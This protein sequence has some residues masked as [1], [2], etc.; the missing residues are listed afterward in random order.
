MTASRHEQINFI[1]EQALDRADANERKEF[2]REA[3][4]GDA[5]LLEAVERLLRRDAQSDSLLDK[6]VRL[7]REG[8]M[9]ED[10]GIADRPHHPGTTVVQE[11]T[12]PKQLGK[13]VIRRELGRGGMG[14]V[15]EA[16]AP[17][18]ARAVAIKLPLVPP[19]PEFRVQMLNEARAAA[20]VRHPG[21]VLIHDVVEGH[22][23]PFLVF[24]YVEGTTLALRLKELGH[25]SLQQ[26]VRY[27]AEAADA[28]AAAHAEGVIHRDV[29]PQNIMLTREDRVK[30]LD[31]GIARCRGDA[32]APELAREGDLLGSID[33]MSPEQARDPAKVDHR[34]D[35]YSLGCTLFHLIEGTPPFTG[36]LSQRLQ[37]H[38]D[39]PP[40]GL[41]RR[42]ETDETVRCQVEPIV[43]EMMAKDPADR[44]QSMSEVATALRAAIRTPTRNPGFRLD[45]RLMV[46]ALASA[47]IA[48][49][50]AVWWW[51]RPTSFHFSFKGAVDPVEIDHL[52]KVRDRLRASTEWVAE[53][54]A[55]DAVVDV[56]AKLIAREPAVRSFKEL[57]KAGQYRELGRVN[58]ITAELAAQH[59]IQ[60]NNAIAKLVRDDS[61]TNL[62]RRWDAPAFPPPARPT[63]EERWIDAFCKAVDR[64]VGKLA[65]YYEQIRQARETTLGGS[66]RGGKFI[67]R[68]TAGETEFQGEH[69]VARYSVWFRQPTDAERLLSGSARTDKPTIMNAAQAPS[70]RPVAEFDTGVRLTGVRFVPLSDGS[71]VELDWSSGRPQID[72][73]A[74]RGFLRDVGVPAA[75]DVADERLEFCSL[76]PRPEIQAAFRLV[77]HDLSECLA[78]NSVTLDFLGATPLRFAHSDLS[79]L[80]NPLRRLLAQANQYRG[81]PIVVGKKPTEGNECRCA[82]RVQ[83][84]PDLDFSVGFDNEWNIRFTGAPSVAARDELARKL[85]RESSQL[86]PLGPLAT[87]TNLQIAEVPA[88]V[89]GKLILTPE[90]AYGP[91]P[92]PESGAEFTLTANGQFHVTLPP[93]WRSWLDGVTKKISPKPS[94]ISRSDLERCVRA[95][96]ARRPELEG[97]VEIGGVEVGDL[98]AL[99]TLSVSVGDWPQLRLGPLAVNSLEKTGADIDAALSEESLVRASQKQ[100]TRT[101]RHPRFGESQT[102]LVSWRPREGVAEVATQMYFGAIDAHLDVNERVRFGPKRSSV[103]ETRDPLDGSWLASNAE[104]L[105]ASASPHINEFCGGASKA[106]KLATGI[107]A[108]L[109]V[110]DDGGQRNDW[111]QLSPPSLRLKGQVFIPLL[112]ARVEVKGVSINERGI[113]VSRVPI[114]LERTFYTTHFAVSDPKIVIDFEN[115][116]LG[117]GVSITPPMPPI[118]DI[119]QTGSLGA[120]TQIHDLLPPDHATRLAG[121]FPI[122][123]SRRI[124]W[125]NP[126]LHFFRADFQVSGN[127]AERV[128]GAAVAH[129]SGRTS[130]TRRAQTLGVD[131]HLVVLDSHSLVD[132]QG[133][134]SLEGGRFRSLRASAAG[135][136]AAYSSS[137]SRVEGDFAIVAGEGTSLAG[138]FSLADIRIDGRVTFE[139]SQSPMRFGIDGNARLPLIGVVKLH[140]SSDLQFNDYQLRAEGFMDLPGWNGTRR[141]HCRYYQTPNNS[142]TEW[143]WTT[144][145]GREV[146]FATD[147][148]SGMPLDEVAMLDELQN[149]V[150]ISDSANVRELRAEHARELL[151]NLPGQP[152][153]H[154]QPIASSASLASAGYLLVAE[155]VTASEYGTGDTD[156]TTNPNEDPVLE[157]GRARGFPPSSLGV[158]LD[159]RIVDDVLMVVA[160]GTNSVLASV[161]AA[162]AGVK[163]WTHCR[164]YLG[165]TS[166]GTI[167]LIL[168]ENFDGRAEGQF[169]SIVF[170]SPTA[171]RCPAVPAREEH[172]VFARRAGAFDATSVRGAAASW[173]VAEAVELAING[174]DVEAIQETN[175]VFIALANPP[176]SPQRKVAVFGWVDTI[177]PRRAIARSDEIDLHTPIE[178]AE[179]LTSALQRHLSSAR[180]YADVVVGFQPAESQDGS[181]SRLAVLRQIGRHDY[182]LEVS[183]AEGSRSVDV[184]VGDGVDFSRVATIAKCCAE[185]IWHGSLPVCESLH[186]GAAGTCGIHPLGWILVSSKDQERTGW[187]DA[188]RLSRR[189]FEQ[190]Q[191]PSAEL[192]PAVWRS[193]ES[194][195][196]LSAEQLDTLTRQIVSS[197]SL[198]RNAQEKDRWKAHPMGLLIERARQAISDDER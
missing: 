20:R 197:W 178:L 127:L 48:L 104:S 183:S 34:T 112:E 135:E 190:W 42:P 171:C 55:G 176:Q 157:E 187:Q 37:A 33:Y 151:Q 22:D 154:D 93:A 193:P 9:A 2:V 173:M 56:V 32:Q 107:D 13:F 156:D 6:S 94:S 54:T 194:R 12:L 184:K 81:L 160:Q 102:R 121:A 114:V 162:Q 1:F 83:N 14:V 77:H 148:P 145:D 143:W 167:A 101:T 57:M 170:D 26:A 72:V 68:T 109:T 169:V 86:Q 78:D 186:I 92:P 79:E 159:L 41:S 65:G 11:R 39:A 106:L 155:D 43:R 139:T 158:D 95:E 144:P 113:R 7:V 142:R 71:G 18:V 164:R 105:A 29:K 182:L 168:H 28:L 140:G 25:M 44:P 122:G 69:A 103:I 128:P 153:D 181:D 5:E 61:Y 133:K 126:W 174:L 17:D 60:R 21:V 30:V 119:F 90:A 123:A 35:I 120:A 19:T 130:P 192:L 180:S 191:G 172:I 73:S 136:L 85:C 115:S 27:I 195:K 89:I 91:N 58:A 52:I 134:V 59:S 96:L 141:L 16:W 111:L 108:E 51:T 8:L 45:R 50:L 31:L 166:V 132:G 62:L 188:A 147:R 137:L 10:H 36:D 146:H 75:F 165:W 88:R 40:R 3:C 87:V 38:R 117:L 118:G 125:D 138:A 189:D 97:V 82:V 46:A 47:A 175:G 185:S 100:W 70:G 150:R 163:D 198:L 80:S 84:C 110:D 161:T 4:A 152:R 24:E 177:G 23:P 116:G 149:A 66:E 99:V 67:L 124:R 131:G 64:D 49:I 15:Y 63:D 53:I 129:P 74:F 98:G 179:R 196:E 76:G